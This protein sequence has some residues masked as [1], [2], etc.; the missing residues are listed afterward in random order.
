MMSCEFQSLEDYWQK[1]IED[2]RNFYTNQL[3]ENE[4]QFYD[5]ESKIKEYEQLMLLI[6]QKQKRSPYKLSPI[7]EQ[8]IMEDEVNM[9][10][11][12]IVRLKKSQSDM[13]VNHREEIR[14]L[15]SKICKES[16]VADV[17]V[18]KK[19]SMFD[20]RRLLEES[21]KRVVKN[22][23]RMDE[24]QAMETQK[25]L[26]RLTELKNYIQSECDQLLQRRDQ[27]QQ[28]SRFNETT[29]QWQ[30][31]QSSLQLDQLLLPQCETSQCCQA[32]L[33][34]LLKNKPSEEPHKDLSSVASAY[35]V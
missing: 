33:P 30:Y 17:Q 14:M 15:E 34:S 32:K 27:L 29:Y 35:K 19:N 11:E 21:W 6:N 23:K 4:T 24:N 2:E 12:E 20:K 3:S 16:K 22:N 10:Q 13:S 9:L 7:E 31:G 25:E 1:K 18:G 5:L 8:Q 28:E 26:K